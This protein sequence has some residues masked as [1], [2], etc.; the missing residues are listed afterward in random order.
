MVRPRA[1]LEP[2][3]AADGT[4]AHVSD[5]ASI[6]DEDAGGEVSIDEVEFS[7]IL[8]KWGFRGMPF[9]TG[10]VFAMINIG[11]SGKINFDEFFEYVR[12]Y[13]HALDARARNAMVRSLFIRMPSDSEHTLAEVCMHKIL[14]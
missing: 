5:L 14:V 7:K 6:F 13:R 3:Q 4:P 1:R 9:V 10:D 12:G 8:K 2:P 11:R